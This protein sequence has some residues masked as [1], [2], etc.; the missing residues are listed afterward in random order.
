MPDGLQAAVV[1]EHQAEAVPLPVGVAEGLAAVR[2]TRREHLVECRLAADAPVV[3]VLI[4]PGQVFHRGEQA[5]WPDGGE[6]GDGDLRATQ[7]HGIRHGT[8]LDDLSVVVVKVG[9]RHAERPENL[10]LGEGSQRL[11]RDP[12]DD[13]PR[14]RV[15]GAVVGEML[16]RPRIHLP[17]ADGQ[18][19]DVAVGDQVVRPP[20]GIT[21]Q[22]PNVAQ[23]ARVLEQV[24]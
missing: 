4:P 2:P 17:L 18:V 10:G 13:E 11:T 12:P 14:Q 21:A 16:A 3:E 24:T 22:I 8:V 9:I 20:A 6:R 19:E 5:G 7:P 1:A 23:A 15:T